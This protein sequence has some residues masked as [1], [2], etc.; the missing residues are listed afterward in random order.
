MFKL[1]RTKVIVQK[2]VWTPARRPPYPITYYGPSREGRIKTK[3]TKFSEHIKI[4]PL[5]EATPFHKVTHL[6]SQI[7]DAEIVIYY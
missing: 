5:R 7:S 2:P 1:N 3:N 6:I 4:P